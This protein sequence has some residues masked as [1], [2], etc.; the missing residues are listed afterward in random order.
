MA[1][2]SVFH[3]LMV[4]TDTVDHEVAMEIDECVAEFAD[5]REPSE[6]MCEIRKD[7]LNFTHGEML[8]N[9]GTRGCIYE[10]SELTHRDGIEVA[11]RDFRH[12]PGHGEWWTN[13]EL[14]NE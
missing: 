3:E 2:G 1:L 9:D 13:T 4:F 8:R 11:S 14:M 5:R 7:G 10:V 12:D 6:Q